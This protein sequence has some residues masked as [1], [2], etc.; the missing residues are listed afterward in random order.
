VFSQSKNFHFRA[1][2]QDETNDWVEKIRSA[3]AVELTEEDLMLS[4]TH[5]R[6]FRPF[7]QP[8]SPPVNLRGVGAGRTSTHTL[9][10]SGPEVGSVSSLSDTARISQLSLSHHDAATLA[11][12]DPIDPP[13]VSRNASGL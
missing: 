6:G 12:S 2:S 5:A 3:A 4:P 7:P 13:K 1:S 8:N 11:N 10:Y 9:D